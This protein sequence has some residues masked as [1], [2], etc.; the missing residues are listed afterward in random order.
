MDKCQNWL[1]TQLVKY[2]R[3]TSMGT[4]QYSIL[5]SYYKWT[6]SHHISTPSYKYSQPEWEREKWLGN[7][8]FFP[9]HLSKRKLWLVVCVLLELVSMH[10][11]IGIPNSLVATYFEL[12]PCIFFLT[13]MVPSMK[14]LG[15]S[16]RNED[17]RNIRVVLSS[18]RTLQHVFFI[19]PRRRR[20]ADVV[21]HDS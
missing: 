15:V 12:F 11:V 13:A 4:S 7:D 18:V 17:E 14:N 19:R 1:F 8:K 9:G 3:F 2:Q 20:D 21:G 5:F 10:F 16:V 6:A